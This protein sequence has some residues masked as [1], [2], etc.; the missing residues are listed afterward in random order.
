[1]FI[2]ATKIIVFAE[3]H[4][5]TGMFGTHIYYF[6]RRLSKVL[7]ERKN[8][9]YIVVF[10]TITNP[11]EFTSKLFDGEMIHI[12]YKTPKKNTTELYCV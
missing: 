11:V 12:E 4:T 1:M 7:I 5:Y 6:L 8:I 9:Q 2:A 10:V 3:I